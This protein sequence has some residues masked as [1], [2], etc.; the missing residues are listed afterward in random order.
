VPT[1]VY[2]LCAITAL[3]CAGL[4]LRAYRQTRVR[5]LFWSCLGFIGLGLSN[6]LMFTDFVIVPDTDL[7]LVRAVMTC[8]SLS[9]LLFGLLWDGS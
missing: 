2:A 3:L 4:L 9:V 1:L 7:S 6:V 5:L 8:V